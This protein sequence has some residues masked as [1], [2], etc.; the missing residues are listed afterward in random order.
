MYSVYLK[1][2]TMTNRANLELYVCMMMLEIRSFALNLPL[3][4]TSTF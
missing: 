4:R 2:N 3:N 1:I